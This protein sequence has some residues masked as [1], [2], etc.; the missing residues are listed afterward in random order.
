M[1]ADFYTYLDTG[2][3][4]GL[5]GGLKGAAEYEKLVGEPGLGTAGMASQSW[6]HVAIILF[7]ILGNIAHAARRRAARAG[8]WARNG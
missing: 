8:R 3:L 5:I 6:A 7:V 1:A 4:S 2:K